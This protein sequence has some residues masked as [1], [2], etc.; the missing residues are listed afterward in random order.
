MHAAHCSAPR[1][2]NIDLSPPFRKSRLY[3]GAQIT[4]DILHGGWIGKYYK[5]RVRAGQGPQIQ[6]ACLPPGRTHPGAGRQA[7]T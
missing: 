4:I 5:F 2:R 3:V 7:C 6:I 1:Y